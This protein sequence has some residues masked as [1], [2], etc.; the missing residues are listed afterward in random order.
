ME[1]YKNL[2]LLVDWECGDIDAVIYTNENKDTIEQEIRKAR[3][4]W[5]KTEDTLCLMEFVENYLKDKFGDI[6]VVRNFRIVNY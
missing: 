5:S 2:L 4:I 6:K 1:N 3:A